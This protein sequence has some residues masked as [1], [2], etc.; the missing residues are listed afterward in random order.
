MKETPDDVA[1]LQALLDRSYERAGKQVH[2]VW[3]IK[4]AAYE[5]H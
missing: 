3:R 1:A 5:E 4:S 2:E